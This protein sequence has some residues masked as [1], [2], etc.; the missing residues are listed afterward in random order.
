MDISARIS[1]TEGLGKQEFSKKN[2]ES[3][4]IEETENY[5]ELV[6]KPCKLTE[7]DIKFSNWISKKVF[8]FEDFEEICAEFGEQILD[9]MLHQVADEL[10]RFHMQITGTCNA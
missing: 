6:G 1:I 8:T 5:M 4:D 10:V 3:T 9:L 7:E 2:F